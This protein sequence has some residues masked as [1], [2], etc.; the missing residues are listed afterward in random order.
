MEYNW[1]RC[2]ECLCPPFLFY[3]VLSYEFR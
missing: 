1:L 2:N 3:S